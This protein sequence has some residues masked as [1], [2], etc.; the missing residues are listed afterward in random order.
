ML[1]SLLEQEKTVKIFVLFFF[2]VEHWKKKYLNQIGFLRKARE[3]PSN[4]LGVVG[5]CIL[6]YV[7]SC[8]A[9]YPKQES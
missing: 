2:Q 3:G 1:R 5:V 4:V 8:I 7:H 6:Q 9:T